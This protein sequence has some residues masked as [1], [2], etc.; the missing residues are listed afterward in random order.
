MLAEKSDFFCRVQSQI[1]KVD[2]VDRYD[3]FI[4]SK[5][6]STVKRTHTQTRH[7]IWAQINENEVYSVESSKLFK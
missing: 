7:Q 3:E 4:C 6:G 5:L 1:D 2:K